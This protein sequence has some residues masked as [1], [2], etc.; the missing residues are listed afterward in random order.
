MS[1]R[2]GG[3]QSLQPLL[4]QSTL[5]VDRLLFQQPHPYDEDEGSEILHRQVPLGLFWKAACLETG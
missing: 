4:H 3:H 5:T 2:R 1:W